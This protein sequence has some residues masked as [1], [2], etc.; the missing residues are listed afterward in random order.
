MVDQ[1]QAI[2]R[3]KFYLWLRRRSTIAVMMCFPLFAII[4][5]LVAYPFAYS[6]YLSML[7]K[8]ETTFVGFGNFLFLFKRETFWLVVQQSILFA[9]VLS[10]IHI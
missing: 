8:A 10:L 3:G 5:C 1:S 7:N 6:I 9:L 2:R 4:T